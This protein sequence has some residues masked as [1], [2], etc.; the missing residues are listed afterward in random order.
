MYELLNQREYPPPERGY[1]RK[2]IE[3]NCKI[4]RVASG[5]LKRRPEA[6]LA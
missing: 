2:I 3:S 1:D 5:G 4:G 6:G